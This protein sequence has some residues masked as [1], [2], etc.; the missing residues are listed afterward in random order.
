[1]DA[2]TSFSMQDVATSRRPDDV[3]RSLRELGVHERD[4][5]WVVTRTEDLAAALSAPELSVAPTGPGHGALATLQCR[6]ARFSDGDDH[7]RRR[8]LTEALLPE[9]RM[10]EPAAAARTAAVIDARE[11]P[12]D[13]MPMARTVPVAVLATALGVGR[14]ALDRV[15][16]LVGA[17]CDALAPGGAVPGQPAPDPDV[18]AAELSGYLAPLVSAGED[19]VAAAISVLFQARD[20]TAALIGSALIAPVTEAVDDCG[21]WIE[22][23]VR[24]DAPVQCTRRIALSDWSVADVVVPAGATVWLMLAAADSAAGSVA[25]TFGS[26][27]HACPGWPHALALARGVVTAVHAAGWRAVPGQRVDY[28]PRPNLRL[29][30]RVVLQQTVPEARSAC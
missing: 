7:E 19:E 15:V 5:G 29:P 12:F 27:V 9:V 28:E 1:M 18:A 17:V 11:G 26:G 6:M 4:D 3:Y 14:A 25:P 13:V 23:T 16:A 22:W 24:H 30:C 20:A 10:I 8:A 21:S 2:V